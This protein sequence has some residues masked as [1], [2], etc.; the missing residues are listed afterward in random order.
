MLILASASPRRQRLLRNA[1]IQFELRPANIDETPRDG[2]SAQGYSLRLA[3][4]KARAV[5][6]PGETVLGADTIVVIA[7]KILGKP[8]NQEAAVAM[9]QLLSGKVHQVMTAVCVLHAG[10]PQTLVETTVVHFKEISEEEIQAYVNSREPLDK[11]GAYGIQM[12]ASKFVERIDGCYFN[13]VGLPVARVYELLKSLTCLAGC[14]K[15]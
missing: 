12:G 11:A 7:G 4:E 3:E 6:K 2:E 10:E 1:G 9:L 13:V 14:T 5:A 15:D 8:A